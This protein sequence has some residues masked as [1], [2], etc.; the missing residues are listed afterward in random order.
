MNILLFCIGAG[1][2]FLIIEMITAAFYGL[3]LAL[4]AFVVAVYVFLHPTAD[5][6]VIHGIIFVIA[7]AIFSYFFPKMFSEK[8]KEYAQGLDIYLGER[9]R[10]RAFGED[11]K[12]PLDGVY[13]VVIS[14]D[15][16][17]ENDLVELINRRG[18][19]FIAE[20]IKHS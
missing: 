3:S 7:A 4:S 1:I 13:Y 17:L 11:F 5:F 14:D 15:E 2:I 10:V 12:I 16:L 9:H 18:S 20:K 8:S 19:V 6:D